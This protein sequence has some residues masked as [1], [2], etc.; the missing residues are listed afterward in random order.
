MGHLFDQA[1]PTAL[2]LGMS[3]E[4]YWQGDAWLYAAYAEAKRRRDEEQDW[5]Q[6]TLGMYVYDA[7]QR[8]APLLNSFSKRHSAY[9][10]LDAPY[11]RERPGDA[12][13]TEEDVAAGH[14]RMIDWMLSAR[15]RN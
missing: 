15:V 12:A 13:R 10:W 11:G 3:P 7:I 1:F 2:A 5:Q 9:D 14:Q 8:N 6:W 4:Q